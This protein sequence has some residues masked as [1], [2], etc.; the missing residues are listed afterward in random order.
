M[1]T[2]D[3][4]EDEDERVNAVPVPKHYEIEKYRSG[5]RYKAQSNDIFIV[6][7]PKS[8]TTWMETIVFGIL[9]NGQS[10]ID[11][12]D[13][14]IKQTPFLDRSGQ[15]D[16]KNMKR[17]GSIKTHYRFDYVPYNK[18]SKYICIIRNAKDVCISAYQY[19]I[20][21][22]NSDY[23]DSNFENF[24][25]KFINGQALFGDYFEFLKAM[26]SHKDEEN[27]L[28]ISFEQMKKDLRNIIQQIGKFLHIEL[29]DNVIEKILY[30]SSFNYM[31]EN[32][33]NARNE[34][35]AKHPEHPNAENH[36]MTLVR[37]GHHGQWKTEMNNEQ[38]QKLNE[39]IH[40][41]TK[42]MIGLNLF[43]D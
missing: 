9:N 37:K 7:Y 18:Q 14:Y 24:F 12:I 31:K 3:R 8:G 25:Q 5:L 38:I 36:P 22:V 33:D 30:H 17:P 28:I 40:E 42:D 2:Y 34:Y 1:S 29:T 21:G 32:Y 16:V 19:F 10:F 6:T 26:W 41:K 43:F 15:E 20:N 11:D 23:F 39:I 35:F 4:I 13:Y 27:V